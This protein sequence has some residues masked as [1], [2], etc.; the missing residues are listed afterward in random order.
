MQQKTKSFWT[1]SLIWSISLSFSSFTGAE[2]TP[3][4]ALEK[5]KFAVEQAQQAGAEKSAPADMEAA[6]AW[7][8]SAQKQYVEAR[9]SA[10]W[11]STEKT[12]RIREEVVIYQA[13]MAQLR[14]MIAENK[15]KKEVISK[16][17][18][19]ALKELKD[20]QEKLT[21]RK[22]ELAEAER[23][24]E[25]KA[26]IE[27][28]KRAWEEVKQQ[29]TILEQEKKLVLAEA[30]NKVKEI[31]L[32]RQREV[33]EVRL[34]ERQRAT[35]REKELAA[36]KLKAEELAKEK[37]KEEAEKKSLAEKLASLQE[38]AALLELEK[39]M[40]VE[41]SKIPETITKFTP[42]EIILTISAISLFTPTLEIK[43][44]GKEILDQ[45]GAF[46]NKYPDFQVIVR[47]HTDSLGNLALNQ[48]LSEKRAQ[49]VRE[50]LV[51]YQNILPTRIIAEGWGPSQPVASNDTEFGR[52]LNRRVEIIVI[53]RP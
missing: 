1:I 3:T 10:S 22:K 42:Q 34:Q 52:N 16:K 36:V 9:S 37:T 15:A 48:A 23:T 35:E 33:D 7:L 27:A 49:K 29:I 53:T 50:Y 32:L 14:A 43:P 2:E 19:S 20:H 47:G 31:E 8:N 30:L 11:V 13:V 39:S 12:R 24:Q 18:E 28:E 46:L 40:A 45:V 51:A 21:L 25:L 41:A 26:R 5:A 6:R 44:S 17:L 4:R 38:K